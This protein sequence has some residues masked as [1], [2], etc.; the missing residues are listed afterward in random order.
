MSIR[1]Q[2]IPASLSKKYAAD[3]SALVDEV[4]QG[5]TN[6]LRE[7]LVIRTVPDLEPVIEPPVPRAKDSELP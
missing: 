2:L 3:V 6:R 5:F 7:D 4:R 1:P